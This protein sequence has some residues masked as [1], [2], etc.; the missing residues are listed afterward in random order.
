MTDTSLASLSGADLREMFRAASRWLELNKEQVNAINVFPVPDGDTGTNMHLTMRSTMEETDR[1]QDSEAG[2]VL[3]AMSHG[4]LMGARGNSGVILSQI[5]RGLALAV[6]GVAVLDAKAL[7][8][9]LQQGSDT[10][11][12]A[13]TQ[14]TEGTILTVIRD[15]ASAAGDNS[16]GDVV[17]LMAAVVDAARDSVARTPDLLPVLAEAGVVDAGGQGLFV[18]LEGMLRHLRG[19][20]IEGEA[21]AADGSL[22]KEFLSVVEQ[23]HQAEESPY[24]YCTEVLIEGQALSVDDLR[25]RV[26]AMGDSVLV[27]GDESLLRIHVHTDDPGGLLALGTDAGSLVQ[28]KVDNIRR[29]AERFVEL[30]QK[31][32]EAAASLSVPES[33]ISFIAVASGEGLAALFRDFGC[34]QVVSG[35]PTMNPSTRDILTAI[36]SCPTDEVLVLP[37]DKNIIMAA[38]Q[39]AEAAQKNVVVVPSRSVPQGI[40]A[41]LAVNPEEGLDE[42]ARAMEDALTDVCTIEITTAVRSTEI[43]GVAVEKGQTI[44]VVD[45]ELKVAS[46]S[47]QEA[48]DTALDALT[49][50]STSLITLYYGA[51]TTDEQAQATADHLRERYAGHEVEVAAGG[52]PH[53]LYIVSLE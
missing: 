22:E 25:E 49:G 38:R 3:A 44:A 46:S 23:H 52:Q 11:Y 20:A 53:Y 5:V 39:A 15:V 40:M 7:A 10:A 36:E 18:L 21:A 27:V 26:L 42:N 41:L 48:L 28:V 33:Q 50:E 4:A 12:K 14:P 45:D 51:D 19:E 30:H 13:V 17:A 31:R 16:N 47:P 6:E 32:D 24:G 35:G 8:A 34:S 29:Q 1:R 9:G 2:A 37:N 43:G